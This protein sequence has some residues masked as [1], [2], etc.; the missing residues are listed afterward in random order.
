MKSSILLA[1]FALGCTSEGAQINITKSVGAAGGTVTGGDGTSVNIPM[2]A[3]SNDANITINSVSVTAPMGTVLVGPA[4]DFGPEGTQFSTPVTITLPFD[5]AK[6]PTGRTSADIRIY[7]GAKGATT[8][9][10][11]NSVTV[12]GNNV[13][14]TTTHFT[15]FFPAAPTMATD[16]CTPSCTQTSNSCSCTATCNG[17]VNLVQCGVETPGQVFCYCEIDGQTQ[18]IMPQI[19]SCESVMS[20]YSQCF[21]PN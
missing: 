9:T 16:G 4:Y 7:T 2:G 6:I 1:L 18:S 12:E 11:V 14:T 15:T 17:K 19:T 21:S 20:A 3:L 13:K 8:F 5:S 10:P